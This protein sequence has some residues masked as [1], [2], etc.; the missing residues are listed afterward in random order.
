MEISSTFWVPDITEWWCQQEETHSKYADLSNVA[1][2]IFFII[3]QCFGVEASFSLC[4]D[5]IG[6][7]QSKTTG[8]T[9]RETVVVRQFARA[10]DRFLA[11]TE[12]ELDA[13]KTENDSEMKT[14]AEERKSDRMVKV[15]DILEMWQRSKNPRATREDSC[16]QNKQMTSLGYNSDTQEIV[17]ASWSLFH[18]DCAA[19]FR[20][21]E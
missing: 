7:R 20:L 1:H 19:A 3:P 12:A 4:W 13:T 17:K 9:L 18:D 21:S 6:S 16:A 8:E 15:H 5:N 14:D 11:G 2:D 10:N